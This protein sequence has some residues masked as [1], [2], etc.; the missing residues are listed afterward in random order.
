MVANVQE[1]FK[2]SREQLDELFT[3]NPAG[4]IPAG[5]T[6]GTAIIAPGTVI[7]KEL[8][9]C[10]RYLAW[11][12]KVFEPE[13][14]RLKNLLTPFGVKAFIAKVYKGPSWFDDKECIVIDY[15]EL[16]VVGNW[17]RDE[18]RVVGPRLYLGKVYWGKTS[19]PVHFALESSTPPIGT[20]EKKNG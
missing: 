13:K 20:P 7:T 9:E 2:M 11:Q 8:S 4:E 17:V 1:L 5:E 14:G 19:L 3:K 18:M 16:P 10:I 6:R 12:G 15:S